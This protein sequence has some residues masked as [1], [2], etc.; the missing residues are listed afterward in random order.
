MET[1]RIVLIAWLA[2]LFGIYA[3]IGGFLAIVLL[4]WSGSRSADWTVYAFTAGFFLVSIAALHATRNP[5]AWVAGLLTIPAVG[6]Y[7]F[8][9]NLTL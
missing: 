7:F 2:I 9:I 5:H 3:V 6:L 4:S 8:L 1:G